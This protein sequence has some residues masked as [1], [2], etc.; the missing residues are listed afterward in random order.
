MALRRIAGAP[1]S[2]FF[3][4]PLSTLLPQAAEPA[5]SSPSYLA[6]HLLDEFSRP[7]AS[8]D[9]ER[10]RRLAAYLTAPA[11]ES[12]IARLPSWRHALDFFRWADEQPGFR[13]SCY[14]FNAMAS[15]LRRGKP[16]H[17]DRLVADALAAGCPM[18]PGALG[19][20]LR[21]LGDAGLPDTAARL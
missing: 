18:T 7:R 21:C 5:S 11:V 13:H 9:G 1:T 16:A 8:R 20:L 12:V 15:L 17:L 19:F 4:K 6:H 14:S 2:S 10:L 3:F